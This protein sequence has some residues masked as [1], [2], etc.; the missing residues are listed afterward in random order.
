MW[1]AACTALHVMKSDVRA[2][3]H[4]P[5]IGGRR[6]GRTSIAVVFVLAAVLLC[7]LAVSDNRPRLLTRASRSNDQRL[8]EPRG[9]TALISIACASSP[10]H[11]ASRL[12]MII[13]LDASTTHSVRPIAFRRLHNVRLQ[14]LSS[15]RTP[16]QTW[17]I[18]RSSH[19][20]ECQEGRPQSSSMR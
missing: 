2:H 10:S 7:Y 11:P 17:L 14:T 5:T 9:V 13:S 19:R 6:K 18:E 16:T 8:Q 12:T 4:R 20:C 15:S 3:F 1:S